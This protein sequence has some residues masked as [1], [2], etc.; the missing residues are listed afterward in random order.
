MKYR[1]ARLE[2]S[3]HIEVDLGDS[4][5][6]F[7]NFPCENVGIEVAADNEWRLERKF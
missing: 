6:E 3:Q 7:S 4:E 2:V 1:N 5:C